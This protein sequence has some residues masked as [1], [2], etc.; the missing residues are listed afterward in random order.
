MFRAA[1][2]K[3]TKACKQPR[4]PPVGEWINKLWY[5]QTIEYYSPF[6]RNKLSSH[7]KTWKKLK[8]ILLSERNQSEKATHCMSLTI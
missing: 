8:R 4:H 6:K 1:L 5:I 3:T 2:F 7:E